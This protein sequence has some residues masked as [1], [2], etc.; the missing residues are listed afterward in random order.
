MLLPI[1]AKGPKPTK[2][3]IKTRNQVSGIS[4]FFSTGI[5]AISDRK[6]CLFLRSLSISKLSGKKCEPIIVNIELNKIPHPAE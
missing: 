4:F 6:S 5:P 2:N 1:V 3:Q